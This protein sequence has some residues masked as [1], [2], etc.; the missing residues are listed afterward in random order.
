MPIITHPE[1]GAR[2]DATDE[3]V[4]GFARAGW[5]VDD[6][7]TPV[8]VAE[9]DEYAPADPLDLDDLDDQ[10]DDDDDETTDPD[11]P[12]ATATDTTEQE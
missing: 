7:Q 9:L 8:A 3:Q 11:E 5:V 6:D 12:A 10:D 1:T 2:Y 4:K